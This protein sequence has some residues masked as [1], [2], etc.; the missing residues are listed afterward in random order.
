MLITKCG[1]AK[2]Y[3]KGAKQNIMEVERT[4]G[5]YPLGMLKDTY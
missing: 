1:C 4:S 5:A 2:I 3:M